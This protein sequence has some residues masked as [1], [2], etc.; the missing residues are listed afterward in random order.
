M[1]GPERHRAILNSL[2]E[3]GSVSN[4]TLAARLRVSAATL[5][6][7][8]TVLADRS[9]LRRTHGGILRADYSLRDCSFE[10]K[11]AKASPIKARLGL[12]AA[13]LLPTEGTIFIDAGTTCLEVGLALIDR[14]NLI[15]FT[16]SVPLL[17]LGGAAKA[18]LNAIGGELR[19]V[20]MALTGSFSQSWL[21]HLHFDAAVIG[22]SGIVDARGPAT[23][24][25]AE[26]SVKVEA[27]RR[28]RSS[29][30][31]ASADKWLV[32]AAITF[33]PWSSFTY[34][35][36]DRSLGRGQKA[37]LQSEG[38]KISNPLEK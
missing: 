3:S 9:L 18:K 37:I 29:I 5:R 17:S 12:A 33:A 15:I 19:P 11:A 8:L 23:T 10:Q 22:C 38:V 36:T 31:V 27:L 6:R 25:F 16:N 26:A 35:V 20:S 34:V 13:G 32:P 14:P 2:A 1:L 7:D 4:A 28:T 24:E 21:E 30:L